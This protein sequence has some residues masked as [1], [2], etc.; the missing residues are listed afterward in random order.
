[1]FDSLRARFSN[2][3]LDASPGEKDAACGLQERPV[4][5]TE[6]IWGYPPP[7]TKFDLA[8]MGQGHLPSEEE[9]ITGQSAPRPLADPDEPH[10]IQRTLTAL[11]KTGTRVLASRT[12]QDTPH[13]VVT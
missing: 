5:I 10:G 2:Q 4:D 9:V 7:L 13:F 1:M 3:R 11:R 8:L 6:S 12:E